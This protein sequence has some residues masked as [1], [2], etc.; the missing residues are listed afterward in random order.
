MAIRR[1]LALLALACLPILTPPAAAA[2]R[3]DAGVLV[4]QV[5]ASISM[6]VQ[7][8]QPLNCTFDPV[9]GPSTRYTGVIERI[10]LDLGVTGAG[11][12]SWGVAALTRDIAPGALAGSYEG[13]S[14]DIALGIGVGANALVGTNRSFA[15]N[16][17]SVE[18]TIGASLALGVARLTLTPAP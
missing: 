4:C 7:S 12:M 5:G 16:P 14:G 9:S 18:G 10:G 11:M 3:V 17:L 15:L 13:V 2:D 1:P 6:L 8:R